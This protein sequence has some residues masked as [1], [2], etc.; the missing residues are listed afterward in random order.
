MLFLECVVLLAAGAN[1]K[2]ATIFSAGV[3]KQ[4]NKRVAYTVSKWLA[5][6]HEAE[7]QLWKIFDNKTLEEEVCS[8]VYHKE[9]LKALLE[10]M[11]EK[12]EPLFKSTKMKQPNLHHFFKTKK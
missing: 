5:S 12:E 6:L 9:N 2:G 10:M 3:N 4:F 8:F 1:P 7:K 11:S